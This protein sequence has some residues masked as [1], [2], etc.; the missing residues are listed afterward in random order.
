MISVVYF[1]ENIKITNF[2]KPGLFKSRDCHSGKAATCEAVVVRREQAGAKPMRKA[3]P[4]RRVKDT[5]VMKRILTNK[6][7]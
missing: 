7:L 4:A 2:N 1:F 5:D 3:R 6:V